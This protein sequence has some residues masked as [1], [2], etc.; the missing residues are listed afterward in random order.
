MPPKKSTAKPAKK[1]TSRATKTSP[2]SSGFTPE[3]RAAMRERTKELKAERSGTGDDE[4]TVL[5]KIAEMKAPDRAMAERLH[6]IVRKSAPELTSRLW[7]GMPAYAKDGQVICFFQN[8]GKFKARYS[9]LGFSDKARLDDGRMWPTT[10]ALTEL[11]T[12]EE[13]RIVALI[14]QALG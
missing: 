4:A 9:T 6:A 1:A 7:Y 13:A 2:A 5:A 8:A 11:T 10:F 12:T 14:R 3:E